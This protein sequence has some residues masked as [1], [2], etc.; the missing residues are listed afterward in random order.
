VATKLNRALRNHALLVWLVG[1]IG[2]I[3]PDID[4]IP[5]L[6]GI[7]YSIPLVWQLNILLSI[8]T[9]PYGRPFHSAF[10]IAA[11]ILIGLALTRIGRYL[12]LGLLGGVDVRKDLVCDSDSS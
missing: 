9:K 11:C 5:M 4:H 2:G 6:F 3:L 12:S 1:G 7:H 8:T 10:L